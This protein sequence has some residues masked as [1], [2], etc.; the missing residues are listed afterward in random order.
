[1]IPESL[2]LKFLHISHIDIY[3]R[4]KCV[5]VMNRREKCGN[6]KT[7]GN[8]MRLPAFGQ[9]FFSCH[10]QKLATRFPNTK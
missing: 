1:M 7:A 3:T 10:P 6:Q 9:A 2:Y 8:K 4:R 5:F